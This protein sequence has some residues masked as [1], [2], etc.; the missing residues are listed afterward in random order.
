MSRTQYIK[1]MIDEK[2]DSRTKFAKHIGIP[3]TTLQSILERG[4]GKA[5]IDN[6]MKI[7]RGLGITT[8]SLQFISDEMALKGN[9][10]V[11]DIGKRNYYRYIPFSVSAGLPFEID[12]VTNYDTI[13]ITDELLGKHAGNKNVYFMRVNGDSMNNLFP[14]NSL[15]A[16]LPQ[17][18]E[19]IKDG[20]IVVYSHNY[21]YSVKTFYRNE[22]E[23]IFK[24]NSNN[25]IF[26]D[27]VF[28]IND[29]NLRIHGKVILYI[30]NVD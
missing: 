13:A 5:S 21:D 2:W 26:H 19:D 1:N 12:S 3:P 22:N 6:V 7:C 11:Y 14:H 20:D 9:N 25:P 27:Y 24:P 8:D 16:V 18:V 15:I 4:V 10:V 17:T 23:L 30:V 29:E 28:K